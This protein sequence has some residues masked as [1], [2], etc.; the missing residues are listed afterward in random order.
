MSRKSNPSYWKNA[1]QEQ[2][3]SKLSQAKWCEQ[4]NVNI[5]NFRYWKNKTSHIADHDQSTGDPK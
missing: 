2:K 5:H 1:L 3:A 4:N